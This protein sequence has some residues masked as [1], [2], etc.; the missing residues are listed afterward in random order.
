[1]S[2]I[3]HPDE[4]N[5][6]CKGRHMA[7]GKVMTITMTLCNLDG[8]FVD[9]RLDIAVAFQHAWRTVIGGIPPSATAIAQHIGKPSSELHRVMPIHGQSDGN[10]KA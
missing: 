1:M 6:A 7:R 8:M 4:S 2:V 5:G 10:V 3:P 9:S